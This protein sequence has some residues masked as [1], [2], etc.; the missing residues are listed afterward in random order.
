MKSRSNIISD[1]DFDY[2]IESQCAFTSG[3]GQNWPPV[4]KSLY[5]RVNLFKNKIEYLVKYREVAG[6][7]DSKQAQFASLQEA[8]DF[9]NEL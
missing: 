2:V 5:Y 4:F 7:E 1:R 9:Y 3:D 6:V 8:V